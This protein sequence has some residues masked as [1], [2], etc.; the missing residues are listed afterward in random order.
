MVGYALR[1]RGRRHGAPP[2]RAFR[3]RIP[4]AIVFMEASR[5]A[6]DRPCTAR[7]LPPRHPHRM[8]PAHCRRMLSDVPPPVPSRGSGPVPRDRPR[9]GSHRD[10]GGNGGFL[11]A[12]PFSERGR[13]LGQRATSART[14]R[15]VPNSGSGCRGWRHRGSGSPVGSATVRVTPDRRRARYVG[16]PKVANAL[17]G[18]AGARVGGKTHAASLRIPPAGRAVDA[19]LGARDIGTRLSTYSTRT[20]LFCLNKA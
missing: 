20:A 4:A 12:P 1:E 16:K 3:A 13:D 11:H 10:A 9:T 2:L 7:Y 5:F 19:V 8:A 15:S 17:Q 6:V 18:M 14:R